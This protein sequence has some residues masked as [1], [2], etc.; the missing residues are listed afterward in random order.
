MEFFALCF[1]IGIVFGIAKHLCVPPTQHK[2]YSRSFK[3][4]LASLEERNVYEK[5]FINPVENELT[6]LRKQVEQTQ[7]KITRSNRT[8][9]NGVLADYK[10]LL[11]D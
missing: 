6:E 5:Y 4:Y 3:N 1:L 7:K 11:N 8:Y 2:R 10:E 9:T